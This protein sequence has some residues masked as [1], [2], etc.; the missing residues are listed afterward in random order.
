MTPL[1]PGTPPPQTE[2]PVAYADTCA[3]A[4]GFSL[5]T[6]LQEPL[7]QVDGMVA[8]L[9]VSLRLLGASHQVLVGQ[10]AHLLETVACL[11]DVTSD[12]PLSF[13]ESGYYFNARTD[14]V[15]ADALATIV[16]T[17]VR[18]ADEHHSRG[19]PALVGRFPGSPLALTAVLAGPGADTPGSQALVVWRTWHTYPQTG[20]VV[21][22]SSSLWRGGPA[23][24]EAQS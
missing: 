17:I 16:E 20:E 2:L 4:L 15:G 19:L 24:S 12:L 8:G 9:P 22:T 1:V 23:H 14:I 5:T 6:P 3:S 13:Q 21:V 18:E 10:S 11:P 7:A